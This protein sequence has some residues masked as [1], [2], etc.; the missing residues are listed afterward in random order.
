MTWGRGSTGGLFHTAAGV[1]TAL[2]SLFEQ[3]RKPG[4]VVKARQQYLRFAGAVVVFDGKRE[5]FECGVQSGRSDDG[6]DARWAGGDA[7][8][9]RAEPVDADHGDRS[10]GCGVP[11]FG[12]AE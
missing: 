2:V 6:D 10:D 5:C 8:V 12:D 4:S 9:Q 1:E 7:A 11:L 3:R